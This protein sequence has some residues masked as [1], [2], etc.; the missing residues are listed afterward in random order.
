MI[1]KV[2][3]IHGKE[4][5]IDLD[6]LP[7]PV[8]YAIA[9]TMSDEVLSDMTEEEL[10]SYLEHEHGF[11][12]ENPREFEHAV[13]EAV[14]D[15]LGGDLDYG[16]IADA[17]WHGDFELEKLIEVLGKGGLEKVKDIVANLKT[18]YL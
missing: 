10:I 15:A 1:E 3:D 18:Q 7:V 5:E 6:D 8:K 16:K 14:S 12:W 11:E 4:V 13:C 9:Q 2:K 17:F